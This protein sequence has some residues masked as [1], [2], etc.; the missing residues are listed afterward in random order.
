VIT[1]RT[2]LGHGDRVRRSNG[3][4]QSWWSRRTT[5]WFT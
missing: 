1:W 2:A 4:P 5:F 3:K